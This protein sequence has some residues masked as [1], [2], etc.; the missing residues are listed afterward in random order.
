MYRLP[1]LAG[2]TGLVHGFS[3]REEGNQRYGFADPKW[4]II[5]NRTRFLR[6]VHPAADEFPFMISVDMIP[7]QQDFEEEIMIVSSADAGRGMTPGSNAVRCEAMITCAPD[8]LLNLTNGDCIGVLM[9]DPGKH[10]V[11]LVHAGRESTIRRIP[12]KTLR[13]MKKEF[14]VDPANVIVGMG[15]GIRS[16]V[17]KRLPARISEDSLWQIHCHQH[18]RGFLV[19]LFGYN[20]DCLMAAG[21]PEEQIEECPYDTYARGDLFFSHYR[22]ARTGE[23]EGR[24]ACAIGMTPAE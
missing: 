4:R 9:A 24:H 7:L 23:P 14:G 15:P 12:E 18:G 22:S 10:C 19:D 6:K 21:V 13:V 8:L 17:L 1:I 3:T 20:R 11:A 2:I 16:Y 5:Q